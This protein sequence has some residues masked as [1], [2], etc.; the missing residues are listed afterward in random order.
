M[1]IRTMPND[2]T[3]AARGPYVGAILFLHSKK[4]QLDFELEKKEENAP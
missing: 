4:V 2:Q 3:S 1:L